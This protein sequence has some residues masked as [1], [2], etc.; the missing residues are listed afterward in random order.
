MLLPYFSLFRLQNLNKYKLL[1]RHTDSSSHS[2]TTFSCLNHLL[3]SLVLVADSGRGLSVYDAAVGQVVRRTSDAH[4]KSVHCIAMNALSPFVDS[5]SGAVSVDSQ[6]L[7]AT[8]AADSCMKLWDVR[9]AEC[10]RRFSG[11]HV[12]RS[13]PVR[14]TF[15]PCGRYIACGSED[16]RAYV[17]DL[18]NGNIV[19]RYAMQQ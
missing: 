5:S 11:G 15:S 6:Q 17:Y 19:E 16:N 8:V 12:N 7:Y 10:V 9:T 2:L 1:F 3:S 4:G 18:G 13:A 14:A